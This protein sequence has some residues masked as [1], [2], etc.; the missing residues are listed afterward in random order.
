MQA[1]LPDRVEQALRAGDVEKLS[2]ML[3]SPLVRRA[4]HR[5]KWPPQFIGTLACI[6]R[7]RDTFPLD[8]DSAMHETARVLKA[9]RDLGMPWCVDVDESALEDGGCGSESKHGADARGAAARLNEHPIPK[10]IGQE[11]LWAP[12]RWGDAVLVLRKGRDVAPVPSSGHARHRHPLWEALCAKGGPDMNTL[13]AL[14]VLSEFMG[15][16]TPCPWPL[17]L[18]GVS[19]EEF[20]D[21]PAEDEGSARAA[22]ELLLRAPRPFVEKTCVRLRTPLAFASAE[23][24]SEWEEKEREA[25]RKFRLLLEADMN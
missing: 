7:G 24:K 4:P 1:P 23:A 14:R 6:E 9:A 8:P 16:G 20:C 25:A 21:V 10:G 3:E 17:G 19:P 11:S 2:E 5:A 18:G 13:R 22:F 12:A 15:D